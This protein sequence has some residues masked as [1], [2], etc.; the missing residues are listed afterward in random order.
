MLNYLCFNNDNYSVLIPIIPLP[1]VSELDI[2]FDVNVDDDYDVWWLWCADHRCNSF[3]GVLLSCTIAF[4]IDIRSACLFSCPLLGSSGWIAGIGLGW[5]G[6]S[7]AAPRSSGPVGMV[8]LVGPCKTFCFLFRFFVRSI[9]FHAHSSLSLCLPCFFVL[10]P[11]CYSHE[12]FREKTSAW[13]PHYLY[14]YWMVLAFC[15]CLIFAFQELKY[16]NTN[17]NTAYYFYFNCSSEL[18]F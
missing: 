17:S 10:F 3:S 11:A 6:N 9:C 4:N 16:N 15:F 12:Q 2:L 18:Y 13:V 5:L 14:Q 8:G 7:S 1:C